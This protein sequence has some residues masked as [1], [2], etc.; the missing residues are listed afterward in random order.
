[1]NLKRKMFL[2][3]L[4]VVVVALFVVA[5]ALATPFKLQKANAAAIVKTAQTV[6]TTIIT[7]TMN[8]IT[9]TDGIAISNNG[10][11]IL[12]ITNDA[13]TSVNVTITVPYE[14]ISG[15]DLVTDLSATIGAGESRAWG[16]F[17]PTYFNEASGA[18][19][20]RMIIKASD[21]AS[22]TVAALT[23]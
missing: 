4:T 17:D 10:D 1:M 8:T 14:P 5:I 20:G 15:L 18:N 12:Y 19:K 22:V 21:T 23:W 2:S 6:S 13:L 7:P 16:P 11:M 3:G 9:S